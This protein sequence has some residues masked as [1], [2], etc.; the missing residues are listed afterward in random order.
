MRKSTRVISAAAALSLVAA[1]PVIGP[2][3]A[4]DGAVAAAQSVVKTQSYIIGN[5][6]VTNT[7]A[8]AVP[9]TAGDTANLTVGFT[10][11]SALS[12]GSDTITLADPS[13]ATVF[14]GSQADYFVIDNTHPRGD[15]PVSGAVLASGGHSVTL[16]LSGSVSA[17]DSLT[18]YVV[19]A[20][21]PSQAGSYSIDVSTSQNP[22]ASGTADYE[23][24]SS[25]GGPTFAPAAT[26][27]L[28][29]GTA[30]YAIGAF[31][32]SSDMKAGDS[33][34]FSS[35]PSAGAKDNVGFPTSTSAYKITDLTTNQSGAPSSVTVSGGT[36]T[37]RL[38]V[39]LAAGDELSVTVTGVH[40]PTTTQQD[41]ISAA[42]PANAQAVSASVQIGTA[43]AD[44]T[45]TLS[46]AGAGAKGVEYVVGFRA[47]SGLPAGGDIAMEAP[48]GTSFNGVSATLVDVTNPGASANIGSGS[49][50]ISSSA[51]SSS[52]NELAF[53]VPRGITAGDEVFVEIQ[54]VTNPSAGN[55]GGSAGDFNIV[56][57][58]DLIPAS[59]PAYVITAAPA[60]VLASIELSSTA[61]K[62]GA[63]YLVR[64]LRTTSSLAAGNATIELKAPAGTVLPGSAADYVIADLTN[65]GA[66]AHPSSV[67][68][69]GT[70]DVV[71]QLAANIGSGDYL[72]V[73]ALGVTNPPPGQYDISLVGDLTA[74]VPPSVQPPAPPK[75]VPQPPVH[76]HPVWPRYLVNGALVKTPQAYYV[77]YHQSLWR[78]LGSRQLVAVRVH[79]HVRY[80]WRYGAR[81]DIPKRHRTVQVRFDGRHW[82]NWDGRLYRVGNLSRIV[83]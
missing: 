52:Q 37:L 17:G 13:G 26:P 60:P 53:S 78:V 20:T 35:S 2:V 41:N 21:N 23:I 66:S 38:P 32:V 54:G 82:V 57:S 8:V 63:S 70:D 44:P 22:E 5:G 39:A 4:G 61:P 16:K 67:S 14:P 50:K 71:L 27:P 42:A 79:N 83:G 11:P 33:I 46:Q 10:T 64:D 7:T 65:R 73:L 18:V 51:G 55:Y 25:S 74:A 40:N 6:S 3:L 68:G 81:L 45:I 72:D 59:L 12:A 58:T 69:G 75:P 30:T 43:V 31:K 80:Q 77:A 34:Q 19:G 24:K 49:L 56:T 28:A 62:T 15:Q 29:G 9:D 47:L 36:V 76:H 48:V 1:G